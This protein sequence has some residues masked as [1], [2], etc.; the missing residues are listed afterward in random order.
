MSSAA[1]PKVPPRRGSTIA[2]NVLQKA[3]LLSVIAI[4][5]TSGQ[6]GSELWL[7]QPRAMD[8]SVRHTDDCTR[9]SICWNG[10]PRYFQV[11]GQNMA[12]LSLRGGGESEEDDNDTTTMPPIQ[13]ASCREEQ[14]IH[15]ILEPPPGTEYVPRHRKPPR[16]LGFDR[17][18]NGKRGLCAGPPEH[19]PLPTPTR[20]LGA[21]GCRSH[22]S[23]LMLYIGTIF[24]QSSTTPSRSLMK[25][26]T[27][28]NR[29]VCC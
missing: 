11:S 5:A 1:L 16:P 29:C 13:P 8:N 15:F 26:S 7:T 27:S 10:S 22:S 18:T 23:R 4:T 17:L 3:I 20:G 19:L 28:C 24:S 12:K 2:P 6:R 25:P 21:M 9:H 14:E